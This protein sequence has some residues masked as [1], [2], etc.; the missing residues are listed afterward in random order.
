MPTDH[1]ALPTYQPGAEEQEYLSA[2][3]PRAFPPIA[4]T[5]DCAILTIRAGALSS[6]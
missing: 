6:C 2:Y 5:V 4:V 3:D 1:R